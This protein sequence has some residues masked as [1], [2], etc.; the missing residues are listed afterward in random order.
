MFDEVQR[1]L[2]AT[3]AALQDATMEASDP[4]RIHALAEAA[5]KLNEAQ[6]L[7][8]GRPLGPVVGMTRGD[9]HDAARRL[10][11]FE[12]FGRDAAL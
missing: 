2:G 4:I 5:V 8:S 10:N 12:D 6:V 3:I 1:H 11:Y 7:L 9:F